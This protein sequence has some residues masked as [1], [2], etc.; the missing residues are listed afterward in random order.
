LSF[1]GILIYNNDDNI[2]KDVQG[3]QA[4]RLCGRIQKGQGNVC[5][6]RA[7]TI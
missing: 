2:F 5:V 7:V 1:S 4:N 6:H 3:S